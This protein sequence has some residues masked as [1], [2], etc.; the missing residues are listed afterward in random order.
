MKSRP[1]VLL[2]A[3]VT[4]CARP[5][6]LPPTP[7]QERAIVAALPTPP[8]TCAERPLPVDFGQR[9]VVQM[10][11]AVWERALSPVR[12]A[13]CGC[14]RS[15][16]RVVVTVTPNLGE[17]RARAPEDPATDA[18]LVTKLG[19]GRFEA[20]DMG[21][22]SD[23]IHCGPHSVER[24]EGAAIPAWLKAVPAKQGPRGPSFVMP[25]ELGETPKPPPQAI[26]YRL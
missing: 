11:L 14:A 13:L 20:F 7:P 18:C 12:V 8:S 22:G 16:V 1:L 6:S 9:G 24:P 3:S 23:C 21:E 17:V 19:D 15:R 25:I 26:D 10:P 5:P 2:L 4:A